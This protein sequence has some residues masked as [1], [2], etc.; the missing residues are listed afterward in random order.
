VEGEPL[1]GKYV[2]PQNK[3]RKI[4]ALNFYCIPKCGARNTKRKIT[5]VITN[6]MVIIFNIVFIYFTTPTFASGR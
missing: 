4:L 3:A 2:T 6:T 1:R 5:T